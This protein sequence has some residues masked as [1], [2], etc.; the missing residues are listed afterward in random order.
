MKPDEIL[1]KC[2]DL[3][4]GERASQHGDYTVCMSD[5]LNW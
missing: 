1:Q 5:L 3:V 2:L 4:T